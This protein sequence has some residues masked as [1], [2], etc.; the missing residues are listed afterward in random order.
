MPDLRRAGIAPLALM[1]GR[2]GADDGTELL[3]A[4]RGMHVRTDAGRQQDGQEGEQAGNAE[5]KEPLN[6][7]R[8][9]GMTPAARNVNRSDVGSAHLPVCGHGCAAAAPASTCASSRKR[10]PSQ[11]VP[12]LKGIVERTFM[13]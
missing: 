7:L 2:F 6:H 1:S 3:A 8:G 4:G 5:P 10:L 12:C 11:G 13:S 9:A